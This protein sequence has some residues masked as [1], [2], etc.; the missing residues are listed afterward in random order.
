MNQKKNTDELNSSIIEY[1]FESG[2]Q[3]SSSD[4]APNNSCGCNELFATSNSSWRIC[5]YF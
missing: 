4:V 3:T 1:G 5:Y 2:L